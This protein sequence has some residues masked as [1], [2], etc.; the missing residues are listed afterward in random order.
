MFLILPSRS[1]VVVRRWPI[2]TTVIVL[3]NLAFWAA[4]LFRE[5]EL[6]PQLVA[7]AQEAAEVLG[8]DQDL[9]PSE[10]LAWVIAQ[11][12][13][14]VWRMTHPP[15]QGVQAA[16]AQ[17]ALRQA[18]AARLATL[19]AKNHAL[20]HSDL[21][22]YFAFGREQ[23]Q[24]FRAL[25]APYI[26]AGWE[27]L[28][29]NLW[30]LWLTGIA[31][32]DRLGRVFYPLFYTM[33]GIAAGLAQLL[34]S[35][36]NGIGASGAIAAVMGAFAVL[37]PLAR[38]HLRVV[39]LV[40]IPISVSGRFGRITRLLPFPPV[41]LLWAAFA[42]PSAVV[43]S[44]WF[45]SELW[46]GA[47]ETH[48]SIGHW[49]HAGGFG[50]G[51]LVAITMRL[52]GLDERLE[53]AVDNGGALLQSSALLEASALIDA[54]KPGVAI[55]RLRQL[56]ANPRVSPIDVHLELLRAAERVGSR[57]D[58]LRARSAL[59]DLYWASG[60]PVQDLLAETRGRGL[61]AELPAEL[62]ARLSQPRRA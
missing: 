15:P 22:H 60:G 19:E 61:E 43:L 49:A 5:H 51:A 20:L 24:L 38:I 28:L 35:P 16:A 44:V 56:A 58:E 13:R 14:A 10:E 50:F 29:F 6:G 2:W 52:S 1:D 45:G 46:F 48:S 39:A 59:L 31:L 62:R 12:P 55:V 53:R 36:A 21:R 11:Q 18:Y 57:K 47:T 27:H 26:H 17:R 37:L 41:S 34:A 33:G 25:L 54:G 9:R 3:V 42:T 23:P 40:P 4:T 8:D 32:E 7:T 30:F